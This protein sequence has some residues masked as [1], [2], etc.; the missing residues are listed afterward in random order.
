MKITISKTR[1]A[2]AVTIA[3]IIWM[4]LITISRVTQIFPHSFLNIVFSS[5]FTLVYAWVYF[6]LAAI[7]RAKGQK[8]AILVSFMIFTSI[9]TL[10]SALNI[11]HQF[12]YRVMVVQWEL[13]TSLISI[14]PCCTMF[15]GKGRHRRHII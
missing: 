1:I 10:F 4:I 5:V 11:V 14:K 8:Q 7:L 13:L 3:Y 2:I 12:D 6:Y 15:Q 9:S